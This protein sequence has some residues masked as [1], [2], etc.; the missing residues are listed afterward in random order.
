[1]AG[2][3]SYG[4][5]RTRTGHG[6]DWLSP[7]KETKPVVDAEEEEEEERLTSR[8]PAAEARLGSVVLAAGSGRRRGGEV[9]RAGRPDLGEGFWRRRRALVGTGERR[10]RGRYAPDSVE[11]G[12]A[13][14]VG[15][16]GDGSG[17]APLSFTPFTEPGKSKSWGANRLWLFFK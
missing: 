4:D 9:R 5:L 6:T 17:Q 2:D 11:S 7:S 10:R 14:S 8:W 13:A 16:D 12:P 3:R 15:F 1:M